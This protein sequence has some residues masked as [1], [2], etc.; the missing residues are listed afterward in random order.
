MMAFL[1]FMMYCLQEPKLTVS[2]PDFEHE[3]I[4]PRKFTCD[5]DDINPTLL[6]DGI[7][8]ECKSLVVIMEDPDISTATFNHWIVWNVPPQPTLVEGSVNGVEGSNSLGKN[9]YLGP[10]PAAGSHRYFFKVF[11]LDRTL[12]LEKDADKDA[13]ERAMA[14]YIL[15]QGEIMGRYQRK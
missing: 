6:I 9:N 1:F 7:P 14:P 10:C 11:A 12:G 3:G 4:L 13:L 8:E 2:S 5:G 15:A